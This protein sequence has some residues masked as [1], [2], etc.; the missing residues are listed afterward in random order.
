MSDPQQ[1]IA[2]LEAEID[3]LARATERCRKVIV[4]AKMA[5]GAGGLLLILA[6]MG[7]IRIGPLALVL[8]ITAAVG[9]LALFGSHQRTGAEIAARIKA[10]GARRAALIDA[11]GLQAVSSDGATE[12]VKVLLAAGQARADAEPDERCA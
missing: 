8:A 7:L 12:A 1:E 9:G 6:L 2:D 10:H 5:T 3:A 4:S 11:M